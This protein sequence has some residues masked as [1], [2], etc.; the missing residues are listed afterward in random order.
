MSPYL[1][2]IANII[3]IIRILC[4]F[5]ILFCPV[6]SSAFYALYITAGVSDMLDGWVAR[7]IFV[8]LPPLQRYRKDIS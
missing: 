6:F 7:R 3:T 2:H 5:A 8:L 4:S 1:K